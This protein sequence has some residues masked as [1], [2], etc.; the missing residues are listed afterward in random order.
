[1]LD[2]SSKDKDIYVYDKEGPLKQDV[3]VLPAD[4]P[5]ALRLGWTVYE[6]IG[7][8]VINNYA[9][10]GIS[11]FDGI[12]TIERAIE[13]IFEMEDYIDPRYWPEWR[14]VFDDDSEMIVQ[15]PSKGQARATAH[16]A[17]PL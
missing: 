9:L 7:V 5:K 4:D 14:V 16:I 3:T 10:A 2:K 1:M 11:V 17:R 15:A 8:A 13:P 12:R 6:E